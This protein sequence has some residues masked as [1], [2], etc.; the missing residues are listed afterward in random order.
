MDGLFFIDKNNQLLVKLEIDLPFLKLFHSDACW[1]GL[2][3]IHIDTRNRSA[4]KLLA[5]LGG[6]N[7]HAVFRIDHRRIDHF[8]FGFNGFV[9]DFFGTVSH[10]FR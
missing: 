5:T 4:L 1:F 2:A 7:D 3:N 9:N 10:N 8:F 6:K